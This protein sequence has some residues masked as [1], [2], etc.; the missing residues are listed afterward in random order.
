[1]TGHVGFGSVFRGFV[2]RCRGALEI[3]AVLARV[4][5][6]CG[7]DSSEVAVPPPRE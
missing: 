1:M 3:M 2:A 7:L 4:A 6:H 5:R